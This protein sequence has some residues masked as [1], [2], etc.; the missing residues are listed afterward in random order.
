[1]SK[2]QSK[3]KFPR[4]AVLETAEWYTKD[5]ITTVKPLFQLLS[6]HIY[7]G[8]PNHFHYATFTGK[9][10]FAATFK[11][12][13]GKHGVQFIYIGAHGEDDE[14]R[15]NKQEKSGH[16]SLFNPLFS[17][18]VRGAAS[19]RGVYLAGCQL[20]GLAKKLSSKEWEHS[21]Q[22]PWFAGYV[23]SVNWMDASWMDM[24]FWHILLEDHHLAQKEGV[25]PQSRNMDAMRT[26]YW[27]LKEGHGVPMWDLGLHIY[28]H[29]EE[30]VDLMSKHFLEE[31]DEGE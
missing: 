7:D 17:Q 27:L 14:I 25:N 16:I 18:D 30:Y 9:D 10:S 19:I 3:S 4:L 28:R 24:K 5:R 29:G 13:V 23:E 21:T 2:S 20:D 22:A 1:M 26:P 31:M 6:Q 11:D 8:D 15:F 12:M